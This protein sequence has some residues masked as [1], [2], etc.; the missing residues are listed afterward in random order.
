MYPEPNALFSNLPRA[1]IRQHGFAIISAIF[2]IVVLAALGAFMVTFSTAQQTTSAQDLQGTRA[3][4]AARTGI[5]WGAYQALQK[6]SCASSTTI[7]PAGTL[8][9]FSVT[10][11]CA[12]FGPYTEAGNTVTLYQITSTANQGIVGS[13]S[14]VERRLQATIGR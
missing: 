1:G 8:S 6:A 11:Q 4:H 3:Y 2:L 7:A 10:V 9:G 5:E 13:L 14:Y 12:P